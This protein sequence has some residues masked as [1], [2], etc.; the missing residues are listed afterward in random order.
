LLFPLSLLVG[1]ISSAK[2][3]NEHEF[4]FN[5]LYLLAAQKPQ[6]QQLH[7]AKILPSDFGILAT[8]H[9]AGKISLDDSEHNDLAIVS[10]SFSSRHPLK[11]MT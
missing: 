3:F 9:L 8:S 7:S 2:R 5:N 11:H 6:G 4:G 1:E 10:K